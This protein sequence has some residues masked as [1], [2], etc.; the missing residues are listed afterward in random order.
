MLSREELQK[1][2]WYC[3]E[4]GNFNWKHKRGKFPAGSNAGSN[5]KHNRGYVKINI[6]GVLYYAHRLAWL[7]LHGEIPQSDIDHINGDRSDN[8]ANNLR[9]ASRSE[10][11]QNTVKHAD[12][13]NPRI[14]VYYNKRAKKWIAKICVFGKQHNLGYFKD[15]ES[16]GAAYDSAKQKMHLF[17]PNLN[18]RPNTN[19]SQ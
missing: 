12:S 19:G 7:Y 10:N 2:L 4:T 14:G 15:I 6:N 9:I 16:A 11:M 17:N 5:P 18:M 3:P 8:R 13:T 1:I